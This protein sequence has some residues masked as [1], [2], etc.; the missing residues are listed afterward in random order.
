MTKHIDL[1]DCA[2]QS[3]AAV[4]ELA[5]LRA[6]IATLRTAALSAIVKLNV[7]ASYGPRGQAKY[8]LLATETYKEV[9]RL[10][11]AALEDGK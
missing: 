5:A 4:A 7:S 2:A 10:L 8:Q 3:D 6:Q 11:E 1:D 9:I